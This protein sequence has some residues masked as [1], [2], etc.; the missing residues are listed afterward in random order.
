MAEYINEEPCEFIYNI[1]AIEKVIDGDT[2]DA[3][4]DL[5]F[6]VRFCGRIRLLGI[7]TPESRTRHKNEKIYGKLSK[8]ALSSWLHWA[9]VDDRDDIEIQVR[10]PEADSRG[11]FGR[12]LGEIW[13]NCNENGHEF[14][15]WTNLNK[16]MC[17]NG[18]AVGYT[19][20]NKDAVKG[21]HWKNRELLE[22]HGV[23]ECLQWDE[24]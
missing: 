11:K 9:I 3:V 18:Y 7:D 21:E 20:Q 17:E 14:G 12:I 24:D 15:G 23:Q 13:I 1:T 22:R 10:C 4:I 5:G 16:W 8:A 6:D 2:I 19:G